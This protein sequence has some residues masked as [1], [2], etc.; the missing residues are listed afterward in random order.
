MC[1]R[2]AEVALGCVGHVLEYYRKLLLRFI[3]ASR[4]APRPAVNRRDG[5]DGQDGRTQV[6]YKLMVKAFR[7]IAWQ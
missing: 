5:T 4:S 7:A 3:G 6:D 1:A 2:N